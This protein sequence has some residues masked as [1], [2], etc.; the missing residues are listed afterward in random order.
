MKTS[1]SKEGGFEARPGFSGEVPRLII[2]DRSVF[3]APRP[4]KMC[5]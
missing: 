4:I 1:S 2:R 5:I 3:P